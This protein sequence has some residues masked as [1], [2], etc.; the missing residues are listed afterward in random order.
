MIDL[1]AITFDTSPALTLQTEHPT[2]HE[3]A[4]YLK[5]SLTIL[6]CQSKL[7]TNV[8]SVSKTKDGFEINTDKGKIETQFLV[9]AAGEFQYPKNDSFPGSN[10][11]IHNSLITNWDEVQ[12][13]EFFVI[14][15]YESGMDTA[16]NLAERNKKVTIIDKENLLRVK[17]LILV[18]QYLLLQKTDL[19]RVNSNESIAFHTGRVNKVEKVQENEYEIY[20]EKRKN[21]F[22]DKA[23][24]CNR[25][26]W[27][28]FIN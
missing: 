18:E 26:C 20:T 4:A 22:K 1:N 28:S 16:I 9:W 13:D 21:S 17:T 10:H 5:N 23:N 24:S 11:C 27:K 15:G 12:G 8:D 2:G 6:S 19:R 3:Y 25:F 7:E 14:G